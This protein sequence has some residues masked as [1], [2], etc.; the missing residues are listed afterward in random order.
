MIV[1]AKTP[2]SLS[3]A[4]RFA[5]L[6]MAALAL[7]LAPGW[8]QD[9]KSVSVKSDGKTDAEQKTI[10]DAARNQL[11]PNPSTTDKL[12]EGLKRQ[13]TKVE[14]EIDLKRSMLKDLYKKGNVVGLKPKDKL[15]ADKKK[16]NSVPPENKAFSKDQIQKMIAE[17]D[18]IELELIVTKSDL[19]IKRSPDQPQQ[20]RIEEEFKRDPDVLEFMREFE[21]TR[22][23]LDH[24]KRNLRQPHDAARLAAQ[25]QFDKLRQEY[26]DLWISK[27]PEV[28]VRLS[29]G[30]REQEKSRLAIQE[31]EQKVETLEKKKSKLADHLRAIGAEQKASNNDTFES[32]LPES[33]RSKV[34]RAG[35]R[36]LRR[37]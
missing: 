5:V 17:M 29:D 14:A 28:L 32:R 13:I 18:T 1:R 24:L 23:H 31:L 34:L 19:E 2:K 12:I 9:K 33:T 35:R 10:E 4:G 16:G 27:Y 11:D 22:E 15:D 26:N 20:Y 36:C 8:A 30:A 6:T 21:E 3:W 25:N 37:I 7:P